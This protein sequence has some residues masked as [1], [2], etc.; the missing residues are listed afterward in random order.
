MVSQLK[1]ARRFLLLL[2][3]LGFSCQNQ[4]TQPAKNTGTPLPAVSAPVG[5]I[6]ITESSTSGTSLLAS[7]GRQVVWN[8]RAVASTGAAAT[9]SSIV[10][11]NSRMVVKGSS[12]TFTPSSISDINGQITVT[13]AAGAISGS[14]TF[15]VSQA[16]GSGPLGGGVLGI[17]S[18]L[19]SATGLDQKFPFLAGFLPFLE[20]ILTKR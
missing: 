5:S 11:T 6:E 12:V 19:L 13:A 20:N 16:S 17:V 2:L 10:V 8:F 7:T 18:T 3:P 14:Q 1:L 9:I 15:L 4:K